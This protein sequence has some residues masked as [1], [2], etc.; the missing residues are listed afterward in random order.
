MSIRSDL[1]FAV[2]SWGANLRTA[3]EYRVAFVVQ[4]GFM[5]VNNLIFLAFWAVFFAKFPQVRGWKLAD[6]ALL[7]AVATVGFGLAVVFMGGFLRL[8]P[9]IATGQIDTWLLRSRPVLLQAGTSQMQLPGFGDIASGILLL[10][11]SGN[12]QPERLVAFVIMSVAAA[13]VTVSFGILC[14]SLAFF[15]GRA[16]EVAR[17]GFFALITFALYPPGLFRGWARVLLYV[18]VPAGLMSYTP[19][20]LVRSWSWSGAG[21]LLLGI[22]AL[23]G[24][25]NL[26]W[27]AGLR[28]YESGNLTQ[29]GLT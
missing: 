6:M 5:L 22:A 18:V 9:R 14:N 11:L 10:F 12:T 8:A 27:R 19:A 21:L 2:A 29:G 13:V 4:A 7:Y 1:G 15:F 26:V 25:T 16:D 23:V 17:Q 28:R 24:V 3:M 20:T